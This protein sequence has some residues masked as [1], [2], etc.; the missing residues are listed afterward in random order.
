MPQRDP[1]TGPHA[2]RVGVLGGGQL[3]RMLA[4]AGAPL[5][6]RVVALTPDP[7]A[8]DDVTDTLRA[9]YTDAAALAELVRRVDVVTYETENIPAA[10]IEQLQGSVTLR[11]PPG[12]LTVAADRWAEKELF[13]RLEI[14]AAPHVRIAAPAD[15]EQA[16]DLIGVPCVVKT[17]RMGYDGKGQRVCRTPDELRASWH[18]L[19]RVDLL[20]EGFVPFEREISIVAV[21]A[22][23]G[24]VSCYSPSENVHDGG[25]LLTTIAPAPELSSALQDLAAIYV[26]RIL[27]DTD[28]VGVLALELFQHGDTLLANEIAPRV[29]NTGHWTIEGAETS[30]FENHLRA[31]LGWPLGSTHH[32]GHSVMINIIG[33]GPPLPQLLAIPG[34][35]VHMYGKQPRPGR[36]LGHV[37]MSATSA[38]EARD[39]LAALRALLHA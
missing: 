31:V 25:I 15:L 6:V 33:E 37:S 2:A 4:L 36:K 39:R 12:A 27:T 20:C 38:R 10:A 1:W 9:E 28:Y 35:H 17:R 3:A 30:Q 7:D 13:A 18:A 5:G 34:L 16:L 11:P 19:G 8:G 29:H 14:P 22:L 21:R 24:A 26:R 32:R 23:D